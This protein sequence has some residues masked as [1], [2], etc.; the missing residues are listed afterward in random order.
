MKDQRDFLLDCVVEG[1]LSLPHA[2]ATEVESSAGLIR[3]FS[4]PFAVCVVCTCAG[5]A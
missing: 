4:L 3:T 5:T 2:V 1:N